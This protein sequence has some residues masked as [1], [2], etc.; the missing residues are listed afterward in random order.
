MD[1]FDVSLVFLISY[2][3]VPR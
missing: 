2:F 1:Y 3:K